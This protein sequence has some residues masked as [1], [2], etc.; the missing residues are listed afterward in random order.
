MAEADVTHVR[1][2]G[3]WVLAMFPGTCH[4]VIV[5]IQRGP[6]CKIQGSILAKYGKNG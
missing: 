1:F 3:V 6:L 5:R 2:K 4:L